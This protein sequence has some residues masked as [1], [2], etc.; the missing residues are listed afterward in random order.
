[1]LIGNSGILSMQMGRLVLETCCNVEEAKIAFLANK[2]Y[3]SIGG[4][5]Y[6]VYDSTGRSTIVE[7]NKDDGNLLFIYSKVAPQDL[8][9][10]A[11]SIAAKTRK[12]EN[13]SFPVGSVVSAPLWF[14]CR[15]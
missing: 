11:S 7:W 14:V 3:L 4:I 1:M 9:L 10:E 6:M 13:Q 15:C 12:I 2:V 8:P 5:H